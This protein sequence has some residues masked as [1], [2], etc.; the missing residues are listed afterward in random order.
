[1]RLALE[2]QYDFKC[3]MTTT[4]IMDTWPRAPFGPSWAHFFLDSQAW[5]LHRDPTLEAAQI[6]AIIQ[7]APMPNSPLALKRFAK[8]NNA[9]PTWDT[10]PARSTAS[11]MRVCDKR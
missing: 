9:Y 1:M 2:L 4:D 5:P 6:N 8:L 3:R 11:R 7:H 10:G